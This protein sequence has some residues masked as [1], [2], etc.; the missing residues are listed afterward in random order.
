M[1]CTSI[2]KVEELKKNQLDK[3]LMKPGEQEEGKRKEHK[4]FGA[5]LEFWC[6]ICEKEIDCRGNLAAFNRHIDKCMMGEVEKE[7]QEKQE[8]GNESVG[9]RAKKTEENTVVDNREDERKS[10]SSHRYGN[11]NM[12]FSFLKKK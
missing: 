4:M 11:S 1:R 3:Y 5:M 2:L 12:L 10:K 9:T 7:K 8:K 6:P